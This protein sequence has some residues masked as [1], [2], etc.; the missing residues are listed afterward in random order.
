[1]STN[2]IHFC[3]EIRK[4]SILVNGQNPFAQPRFTSPK[5]NFSYFS[6]KI[7]CGYP[8][9]QLGFEGRGVPGRHFLRGHTSMRAPCVM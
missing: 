6:R 8:V 1:M 5:I 2:S 4:M 7:C 3:E 9:L